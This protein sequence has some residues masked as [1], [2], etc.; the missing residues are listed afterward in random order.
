M[1]DKGVCKT[2]P[3]T[4]GLL[5]MDLITSF[6]QN[7]RDI[8]IMKEFIHLFSPVT[9]ML[10]LQAQALSTTIKYILT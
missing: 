7:P 10:R 8:W 3:A 4:P 6:I 5:I 1:N 9:S 2:A